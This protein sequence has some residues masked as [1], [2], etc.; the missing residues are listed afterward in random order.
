M[1]DSN[2]MFGEDYLYIQDQPWA[3]VKIHRNLSPNRYLG[4]IHPGDRQSLIHPLLVLLNLLFVS[5]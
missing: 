2:A 5:G 1:Y 4:L 3:V